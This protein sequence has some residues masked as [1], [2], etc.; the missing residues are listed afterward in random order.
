MWSSPNA[1]DYWEQLNQS[2]QDFKP[3]SLC[4]PIAERWWM[5]SGNMMIPQSL[6]RIGAVSHCIENLICRL[7]GT[8][9]NLGCRPNLRFPIT[10]MNVARIELSFSASVRRALT[11]TSVDSAKSLAVPN[12]DMK[13]GIR[14]LQ[15]HLANSSTL[16]FHR[17]TLCFD[18]RRTAK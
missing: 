15:P 8:D 12:T 13:W 10:V 18:R 1:V 5:N 6:H 3:Q 4:L 9:D 11:P 7:T 2:S 16:S 17:T 14:N